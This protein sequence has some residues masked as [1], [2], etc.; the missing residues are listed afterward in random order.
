MAGSF[1]LP[2]VGLNNFIAKMKQVNEATPEPKRRGLLQNLRLS[3]VKKEPS[4]HRSLPRFLLGRGFKAFVL[5]LSLRSLKELSKETQKTLKQMNRK[6]LPVY[7]VSYNDGSTD[8]K[9]KIEAVL[10]KKG[11]HTADVFLTGSS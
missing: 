5:S 1:P 6:G 10:R 11:I 7:I 4:V 2:E 9:R 8:L 3:E